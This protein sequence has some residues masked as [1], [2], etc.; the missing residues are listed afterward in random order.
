MRRKIGLNQIKYRKNR[1]IKKNVNYC[2]KLNNKD[3]FE[4][5]FF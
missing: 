1:S 2:L 4:M 5:I 3:S